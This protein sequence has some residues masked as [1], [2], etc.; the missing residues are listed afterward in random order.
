MWAHGS[1]WLGAGSPVW[2]ELHHTPSLPPRGSGL[3]R[4]PAWDLREAGRLP[5][6]PAGARGWEAKIKGGPYHPRASGRDSSVKSNSEIAF[7]GRTKKNWWDLNQRVVKT[8]NRKRAGIWGPSVLS[9]VSGVG[10]TTRTLDGNAASHQPGGSILLTVAP[11]K[12][13]IWC[14]IPPAVLLFFF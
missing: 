7:N 3:R 5:P 2:W 9:L 10:Y 11:L 6:E 1:P 12:L 13:N 14:R 8:R 4:G